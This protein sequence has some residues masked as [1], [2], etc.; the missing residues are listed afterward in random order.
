MNV[1]NFLRVGRSARIGA[2]SVFQ[3]SRTKYGKE[4]RMNSGLEA[5]RGVAS[6]KEWPPRDWRCRRVR[7]A[8]LTLA[9]GG[10]MLVSRAGPGMHCSL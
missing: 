2:G 1:G 7:G 9:G 8:A 3:L 5:G 4:R 10:T 6:W